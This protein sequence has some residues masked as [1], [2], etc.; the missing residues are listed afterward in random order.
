MEPTIKS[1]LCGFSPL[2]MYYLIKL[3]H[4]FWGLG[5]IVDIH[6]DTNIIPDTKGSLYRINVFAVMH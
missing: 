2:D 3:E 6:F 5:N 1:I 4:I